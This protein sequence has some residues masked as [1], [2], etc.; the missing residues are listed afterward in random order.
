MQLEAPAYEA[1]YKDFD[2]QDEYRGDWE[3]FKLFDVKAKTT[4]P[5]I[6]AYSM[7][8]YPDEKGLLKFNIR[9]ATPPLRQLHE[10]PADGR[11]ITVL[12]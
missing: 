11:N 10:V 7:A 6:R 8:N 5:T 1:N 3:K 9:I 2:I 4:E 12:R